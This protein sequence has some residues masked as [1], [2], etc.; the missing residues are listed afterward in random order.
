VATS[1]AVAMALARAR[2]REVVVA[3]AVVVAMAEAF[4]VVVAVVSPLPT[5][6]PRQRVIRGQRQVNG[7]RVLCAKTF[8]SGGGR[9]HTSLPPQAQQ[10]P[11]TTPINDY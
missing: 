10:L 5:N 1:V 8:F 11:T 9:V 7:G 6:P 2:A 4:V 3:L